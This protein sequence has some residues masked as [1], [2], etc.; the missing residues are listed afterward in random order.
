MNVGA[1]YAIVERD[2]AIQNPMTPEKLR[3]VIDYLQI[4]DGDRLIDVGCGKGWLLREIAGARRVDAVGLEISPA[5]A[6]DARH[7]L[8]A[9]SLNGR[10]EIVEGPA[11]DYPVPD[12]SFD[13][14][15][16]I[17][18]TFALGGLG[19]T[20]AW[21]AAA[22]RPGGRIAVGE[23]YAHRL[24]FPDAVRERW[25][26]YDQ[27]MNG[28]VRVLADHG[29]TLTGLVAA[30]TDDWDHYETQHWRAAADWIAEHPGEPDA[31]WLADKIETERRDYLDDER[32]VFGWAIFVA[33]TAPRGG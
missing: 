14:A 26:E 4:R 33:R 23:P 28:I 21:L 6:A 5:F 8:A 13:I 10:V 2:H 18:A 15:L 20:V 9:A 32:E 29:L 30:S 1:Y 16:C 24:P 17:G 22:V 31:L 12:G 11:L 27:D 25:R 7:N 19:P 3:R